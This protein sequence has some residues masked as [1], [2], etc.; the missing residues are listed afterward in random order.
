MT[1]IWAHRGASA[2]APENTI[3]AFE[4][5]IAM[6]ADGVELDVQR[7]AD[8]E[9]V[10]IHDETLDRT[11]SGSGRVVDR[12]LDELRALDASNG[13]PA[14]TGI[15][16]P[17]LAEVLELLAPTG[18]RVNV[19]LK[20]SV[21]FYPGIEAEALA[22]VEDAGMTERV[23]W[24]SFNHLTLLPLRGR[25][26]AANIGLLLSDVTVEPWR[27]AREF[28]AGA[29]HPGLHLL[30]VPGWVDAAHEAGLAVHV[31]TVDEP[32]HLQLV[33]AAGVDVIITNRPDDARTVLHGPDRLPA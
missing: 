24:S 12:T 31:W 23:V 19:E 6:G 21:E 9:L 32:A 7:T 28:G 1:K 29:L 2:V 14:F 8:G 15:R 4:T 27:Y 30:Q 22:L 10:V 13:A 5:A 20:T 11:T 33:A 25:V 17:T 26:P 16:I 18:M 3:P